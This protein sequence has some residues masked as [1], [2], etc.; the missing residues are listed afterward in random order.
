MEGYNKPC[1]VLKQEQV[2]AVVLRRGWR[3]PR[4]A[5]WCGAAENVGDA[6]AAAPGTRLP[7]LHSRE[8]TSIYGYS[9]YL[10]PESTSRCIY[11]KAATS[12]RPLYG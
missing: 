5:G 3:W 6:S 1:L 9:N 11:Y 2:G 7:I 12:L 4:Q 10:T 8:S